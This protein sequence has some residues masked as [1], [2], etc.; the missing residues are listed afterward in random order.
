VSK[1]VEFRKGLTGSKRNNVV[2]LHTIGSLIDPEVDSYRSLFHFD[3]AY[4]KHTQETGSVAGY[5]GP[6]ACDII[7]WDFD[8]EDL[9]KCQKDS[10]ILIDRLR[11]DYDIQESEVGVYFSGKKGFAIELLAEGLDYVSVLDPNTPAIVKKMC[12]SIAKGLDTLDKTL[13][14]LTRIYRIPGTKHNKTSEVLDG[15]GNSYT[16]N[17]Y[18]T[19]IS[20]NALRNWSMN[21]IKQYASERTP[22]LE[23]RPIANPGKLNMFLYEVVKG[24]NEIASVLDLPVAGPS[25]MLNVD[26]VPKGVKVCLWRMSHGEAPA[27]RD[28]SLLAVADHYKKQGL[29]QT[30]V[31]QLL[32]GVLELINQKDPEKARRDPIKQSDLDRITKQAFRMSTDFGCNNHILDALCSSKCYLAGLKFK[33]DSQEI[34]TLDQAYDQSMEFYRQI[35]SKIVPTGFHSIDS[36]APLYETA[37]GLIVGKPAAGK[38]S[39][40]LNILEYISRHD[41]HSIFYNLD[42]SQALLIQKLAPVVL[43]KRHG[44][45]ITGND[46]MRAHADPKSEV[47]RLY[48]EELTQM[49][50]NIKIYSEERI[51]VKDIANHIDAIEKSSGKK[52]KFIFVDYVQLLASTK[53]SVEKETENATLLAKLAKEKDVCVLGLSQASGEGNELRAKGAS[54]WEERARVRMNC[55]R[56]FKQKNDDGV[57]SDDYVI[58]LDVGKNSLGPQVSVDMYFDGPTGVVRDL[59]DIE[60]LVVKGMRMEQEQNGSK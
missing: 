59:T 10:I 26:D 1:F 47:S 3:E 28:N 41:I 44:M 29:P 33:T 60:K 38:T 11:K 5:V 24:I 49:G 20:V 58:T 14:T 55:T 54:A 43:N 30:V 45:H 22:K 17:L 8:S 35:Q 53:A 25:A 56:P 57:M 50:K 9:T 52:V 4:L 42:M 32:G 27:G 16:L 40:L 39:I 2:D 36:V 6:A 51:Y 13:Y 48:K 19:P 18:K 34:K 15:A 21:E 37:L 23:V 7:V 31:R 46:F 12:F